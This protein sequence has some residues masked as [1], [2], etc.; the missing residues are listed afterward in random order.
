MDKSF[1]VLDVRT[2]RLIIYFI[3]VVQTII[4]LCLHNIIS[5]FFWLTLTTTT[6]LLLSWDYNWYHLKYLCNLQ[7][8][9]FNNAHLKVF[10]HSCS[11][12]TIVSHWKRH[13]LLAS[14]YKYLHNSLTSTVQQTSNRIAL[15]QLENNLSWCADK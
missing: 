5:P 2:C 15:F 7:Q 12:S 6:L 4:V 14:K 11:S 8:D 1:S 3:G 10:N 13:F 9:D